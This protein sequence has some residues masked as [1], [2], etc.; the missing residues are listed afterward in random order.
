MGRRRLDTLSDCSRAGYD[1]RVRC[2]RADCG[3]VTELS[4]ATLKMTVPRRWH[5]IE[6]LEFH[7]RCRTC[8][9]KGAH[10]DPFEP[11]F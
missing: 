2:L 3:R 9:W 1:L 11:E 8:G 4:S 7:M 5:R 10:I 6:E